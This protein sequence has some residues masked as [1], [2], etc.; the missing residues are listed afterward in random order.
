M[1]IRALKIGLFVGVGVL[2]AAAWCSVVVVVMRARCLLCLG[3]FLAPLLFRWCPG[4][5]T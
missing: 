2:V 1:P 5:V 3:G 4:S